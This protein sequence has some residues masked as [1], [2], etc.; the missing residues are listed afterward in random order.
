MNEQKLLAQAKDFFVNL[1]ETIAD[2]F[3]SYKFQEI[4]FSLKFVFILIS[5]ILSVLIVLLIL[6]IIVSSFTKRNNVFKSNNLSPSF[7]TKKIE[8]KWLKIENKIKS[9]V[10]ANYKLAIIEAEKVFNSVLKEFGHDFKKKLSNVDDFKIADKLKNDIIEDKKLE[11][12]KEQ[13]ESAVIFYK[14]GI[15]ELLG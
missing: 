9:G 6:K 14:K 5:F 1:W 11:V 15:E 2:F 13:A 3:G 4:V 7:N 8:K 10:E 12:S